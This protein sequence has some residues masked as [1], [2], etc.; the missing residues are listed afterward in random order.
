MQTLFSSENHHS[1]FIDVYMNEYP[2]IYRISHFIKANREKNFFPVLLQNIEANCVLDYCTRKIS[3]KYP[4]MPLF[5]IHDSIVTTSHYEHILRVEFNRLL[6][7][8]FGINPKLET[9]QWRQG[10]SRVS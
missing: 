1:E 2:E 5:T 6:G 7:L 9:E 3:E 4:E 10:L 8:Y